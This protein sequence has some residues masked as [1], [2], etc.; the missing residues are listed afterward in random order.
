MADSAASKLYTLTEVSKITNIS[1][2]TLQRYKKT[3]QDRIPSEG[4]GR[5]QRYPEDALR[6]FEELK[7]ENVSRRGRPRKADSA[8]AKAPAK[9]AAK[10]AAKPR[11]AAAK[12]A[13]AGGEKLLTLMEIG[14]QTKISYPTLLR[15]VKNNLKDIPHTGTG[16]NRRYHPDAVAIFKKLRQESKTGRK[17]GSAKKAPAAAKRGPGRP[18]KAAA[19]KRGPGRPPKAAAAADPALAAKVRELEKAN[20]ALAKQVARLEKAIAKPFKV[21]LQRR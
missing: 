2:P 12:A 6:V 9:K 7:K 20:K 14:K 10:A 18:P 8:K 3:Y 16:R 19:A 17:A 15:Y 13:N 1:M 21:T 4:K 5:M 11:K